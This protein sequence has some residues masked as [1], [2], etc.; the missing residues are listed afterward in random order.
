MSST[1]PPFSSS[2]SSS[3]ASIEQTLRETFAQLESGF[4]QSAILRGEPTRAQT[5]LKQLTNKMADGKK[6][7]KEYERR[8]KEEVE[9]EGNNNNNNSMAARLD[10]IQLTKKRMVSELNRFVT[11]KKAA[12]NAIAEKQ[13]AI[14]ETT[15]VSSSSAAQVSRLAGV[16]PTFQKMHEI[17]EN[18]D[19]REM[20]SQQLVQHGRGMMN[21]TD[22]SVS[23]SKKIVHETIEMGAVTAAKLKEQTQKLD[24][25]TD[26]LDELQFSVRKS[27]NLVRDITKGLASDRCVITLMLLVALGV[28]AVIIVKATGAD[29]K[30]SSSPAP[31]PE[32]ASARRLLLHAIEYSLM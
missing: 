12:Q 4:N 16:M 1:S 27:L 15:R 25:I 23:R 19:L 21:Q 3:S 9:E 31:A 20:D 17:K 5:H 32:G 30:K 28:V 26:E 8:A 2:S 7:I 14:A 11:M 24:E 6:L 13:A 10:Q 22:K 29:K 18:D